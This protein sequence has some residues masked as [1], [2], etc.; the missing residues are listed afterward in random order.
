MSRVLTQCTGLD[1]IYLATFSLPLLPMAQGSWADSCPL[2]TKPRQV[3]P[4][5]AAQLM[6]SQQDG[7]L[8]DGLSLTYNTVY[9]CVI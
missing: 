5:D 2:R 7:P 3:P 9:N 6:A 1:H 8:S 4:Q